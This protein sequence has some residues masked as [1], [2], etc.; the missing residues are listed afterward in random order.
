MYTLPKNI[1]PCPQKRFTWHYRKLV[2]MQ[3]AVWKNL[4][5]FVASVLNLFICTVIRFVWVSAKF[6]NC[7]VVSVNGTL[8]EDKMRRFKGEFAHFSFS[9]CPIYAH[10]GASAKLALTRTKR[11]TVWSITLMVEAF[12]QFLL[13]FKEVL[14]NDNDGKKNIRHTLNKYC[15]S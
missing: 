8:V 3:Q 14:R 4:Q 2:K 5:I 1:N 9:K 13:G 7:T 6:G 15:S 12:L 10:D 11:I